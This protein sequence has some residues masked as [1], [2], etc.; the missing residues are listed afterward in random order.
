MTRGLTREQLGV[1]DQMIASYG[2]VIFQLSNNFQTRRGDPVRMKDFEA[3]E[4][5]RHEL[6]M[7]DSQIADR[8]GLTAEQVTLIRNMEER[9]RFRTGH[10][11]MLNDLGGGKRFRAERMTPLQ[12]HFRYSPEALSLRASFA[13]DPVRVRG[14]V[15]AGLWKD[16]TLP[17]WLARNAAERGGAPALMDRTGSVSWFDLDARVGRLAA[18]FHRAG[19]RPGDVA[20]VMLPNVRAYLECWLALASLGAVMTTLYMTFRSAE[21][22]QQ[23]AHSK[24]RMIIAP[25]VIGDFEPLA[26]ALDQQSALPH[27]MNAVSVGGQV[28]GAQDFEELA[29]GDAGLPAGFTPPTAA[30]PF[31]LLYTSG[32][33]ASPKG[34]PLNSH[35]MLTNA[36][37]GIAEH[38][39]C[40]G[41]VVLS[42]AP[43]GHLYALYSFEMALAAG[44]S[45]AL[46]P[47]FTPPDFAEA[48]RR[49]K[50]THIFAGPAHLAACLDSGLIA[51][52][53]L[54]TVRQVVLSGAAVPPELVHKL[55]PLMAEGALCQLWGMTELQA[56]LY[57]RSGHAMDVV[58]VSAGRASPGAEVR[59]ADE[60]GIET[61]PGQEGELQIRGPSV[62]A[63]Y[64]ENPKATEAAFTP[65]GWFRSGDLATM[66]QAGNVTLSGRVK[67]VI[68][69]GGVKYNPQEVEMLIERI[70]AVVQCAIAPVP[71]DRLGERA[72][73]Y[74]VLQPGAA[75]GL[76]DVTGFL[77][78]YGLAKHKLPEKLKILSD[79]PLTAT[80][81]VIKSKLAE[82]R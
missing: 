77:S 12:D 39:I 5:H 25:P 24:A 82:H 1:T 60:N 26:W 32:T 44:A 4:A 15:E 70:P 42:A 6:G 38:S 54:S 30:D 51:Q 41:D 8:I 81:K 27:L 19:L 36:R 2:E 65:D 76:D 13:F 18:G 14:Y 47:M 35:Q 50:P 71:D 23:L 63:G 56:G 80:R 57:T 79:M 40:A 52:M 17:G 61:G 78:N 72:C 22:L 34:V 73:C 48:V 64:Y 55:S 37:L 31:L 58:A 3:I 28:E 66:D 10:Y 43:F 7:G 16:D 29:A 69:R 62:F 68:N 21:L 59:I 46:L 9:R 74:V 49:L 45:T 53:D 33:T 75:L 20:A 67:D 11:H